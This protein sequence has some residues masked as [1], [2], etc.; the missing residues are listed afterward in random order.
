MKF[1]TRLG[2]V[3]C[4]LVLS[5]S[6]NAGLISLNFDDISGNG[7]Q[8]ASDRYLASHEIKFDGIGGRMYAYD[9][10]S[11]SEYVATSGLT[12]IYSGGSLIGNGAFTVTFF[13]NGD[14]GSLGVTDFL[15]FD[16]VDYARETLHP[17]SYRVFDI[18]GNTLF[19]NT[20]TGSGETV[21]VSTDTARIHGFTF[22]PSVDTEG[23][24]SFVFEQV[25][26]AN[27]TNVPEPSSILLF[28]FA[29]AGLLVRKPN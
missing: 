13:D 3:L 15:Q 5:L 23:L 20:G 11:G 10:P 7:T 16:V 12:Y 8:W 21:K 18:N 2:L 9:D 29:V 24:D 17:W 14:L 27:P 6:A 19:S 26:S 25:V 22:T 1:F 4:G 28:A